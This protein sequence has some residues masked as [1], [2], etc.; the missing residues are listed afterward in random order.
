MILHDFIVESN[1]IESIHRPP[2]PQEIEATERFMTLFHVHAAT[3]GD[4]QAVFAPGKPIREREGMNVRVGSHIAPPG[5]PNIVRRL[6]AICRRANNG[7]DPWRVHCAFET[8]H[9]Y[10]DGNGRTGRMLWAW[11]MH[12]QGRDPFAIGFL[13]RWYY[14]TLEHAR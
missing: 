3:L 9:P 1:A 2:T 6:N 7:D 5:G 11:Q 8:L 12:G 13:H 4:F 14:Q 10:L